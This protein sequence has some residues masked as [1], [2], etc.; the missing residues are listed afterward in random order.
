MDRLSLNYIKVHG[1]QGRLL[2]VDVGITQGAAVGHIAVDPDGQHRPRRTE[3][4]VQ[5]GLGDV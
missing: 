3:L 1:V 4:F 2:E 5:H